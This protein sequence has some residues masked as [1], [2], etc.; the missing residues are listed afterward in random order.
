MRG[1]TPVRSSTT[2]KFNFW[3]AAAIAAFIVGTATAPASA[4]ESTA[5]DNANGVFYYSSLTGGPKQITDPEIG[6]CYPVI[7]GFGPNNQTDEQA[8]VYADL[9]C[10]LLGNPIQPGDSGGTVAF[11]S[12]RFE[13]I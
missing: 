4:G 2:K 1:I 7:A 11:N 12:V 8:V 9:G 13:D 5:A 3:A 10:A 6:Q